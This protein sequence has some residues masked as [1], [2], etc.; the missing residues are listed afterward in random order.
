MLDV[1]SGD[2]EQIMAEIDEV[3][4]NVTTGL[5]T[6][7]IRDAE[8]DGIQIHK[9]DFIGICNS[10]MVSSEKTKEDALKQMLSK[11]DLSEKE[12]I[13]LIYGADVTEE[14]AEAVRDYIESTYTNIEVDVIEGKQEVYS[15]I[16]SIE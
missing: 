15:Y 2:P 12:I 6:Y 8:L 3:I 13:T 9:D 1:S 14:E 16:L 5:I 10:K 11:T 4:G 7:S